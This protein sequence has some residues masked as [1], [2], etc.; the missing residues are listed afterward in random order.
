MS[1]DEGLEPLQKG[2]SMGL[3]VQFG[4]QPET[5]QR[6]QLARKLAPV[7]PPRSGLFCTTNTLR[8]GKQP[9]EPIFP[10]KAPVFNEKRE[11]ILDAT[12]TSDSTGNV[13][14]ATADM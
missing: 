5:S 4:W 6:V 10:G 2:D 7:F 3:L 12:Y 8:F 1:A 11:E 14:H 9:G 13:P